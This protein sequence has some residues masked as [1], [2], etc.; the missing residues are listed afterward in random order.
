MDNEDMFLN[1]YF[2]Y[3]MIIVIDIFIR[4]L[5]EIEFISNKHLFKEKKK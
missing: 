2:V 5:H 3:F 4:K 1:L